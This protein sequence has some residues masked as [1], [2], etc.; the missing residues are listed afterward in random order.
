MVWL[1]VG[2]CIYFFYGM[3]RS[4]IGR[5][6]RGLAAAP[7]AGPAADGDVILEKSVMMGDPTIAMRPDPNIQEK[8]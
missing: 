6:L 1:I 4:S 7:V 2:L 8:P 3:S 5:G